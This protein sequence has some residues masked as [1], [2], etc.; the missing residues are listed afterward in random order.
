[1][2]LHRERE[3]KRETERMRDGCREGGRKGTGIRIADSWLALIFEEDNEK[4]N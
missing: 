4:R 1:M 3:G 2:G